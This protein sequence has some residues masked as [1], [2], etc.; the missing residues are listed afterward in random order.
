[1]TIDLNPC[2]TCSPCGNPD[3]DPI[4]FASDND[5]SGGRGYT[6]NACGS[7]AAGSALTVTAQP[8]TV[9]VDRIVL[10]GADCTNIVDQGVVTIFEE[11]YRLYSCV[12]AASAGDCDGDVSLDVHDALGNVYSTTIPDCVNCSR[13]CT[14]AGVLQ[15]F[16]PMATGARTVDVTFL[17][18]V[19]WFYV[20]IDHA[21]G[22]YAAAACGQYGGLTSPCLTDPSTVRVRSPAGTALAPTLSVC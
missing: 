10:D 2:A 19:D 3:G 9:V 5:G 7:L 8:S 15:T 6:T 17:T 20:E 13:D 1:M 18:N 21:G 12:V 14:T 11:Q 22:T 4:T 16:T